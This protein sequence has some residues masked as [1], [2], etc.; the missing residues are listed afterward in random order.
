MSFKTYPLFLALTRA[1]ML[2]GVT[3]FFFIINIVASMMI[4]IVTKNILLVAGLFFLM[5]LIGIACCKQDER[6][7]EI[8]LG[9]LSLPCPNR[10]LWKCNS[11]DP[12]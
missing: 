5:H 3:Q 1:P 12:N 9:R 7:F 8:L 11:Y 2:M 6:F 10:S 4:F